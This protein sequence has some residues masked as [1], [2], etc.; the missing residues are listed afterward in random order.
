MRTE[1]YS[2]ITLY[3][4]GRIARLLGAREV[5]MTIAKLGLELGR[6]CCMTMGSGCKC[7]P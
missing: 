1:K 6:K 7:K 3:K 5:K 2:T 4:P